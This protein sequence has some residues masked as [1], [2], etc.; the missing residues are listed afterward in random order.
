MRCAAR[1]GWI[2][3]EPEVLVEALDEGLRAL[4]AGQPLAAVQAALAARYPTQAPELRLLLAAAAD[5]GAGQPPASVPPRAQAASRAAFLARAGALRR[6]PPRRRGLGWLFGPA[7]ARPLIIVFVFLAGFVAGT[8]GAVVAS[9]GALPGD[10]LYTVK[11]TVERTQLLLAGDPKVRADLEAEFTARRIEEVRAVATQRRQTR[12]EFTGWLS[13]LEG[14]HWTVSG[15]PVFVPA[16]TPITGTPAPGTW[17]RLAGMVRGDGVILAE[18][19]S[20]LADADVPLPTATPPPTAAV[21]AG[22]DV[23]FTGPVQSIGAAAWQIAGQTVRVSAATEIRDNPR[24][25]QLVEVRAERQADGSLLATRIRLADDDGAGPSPSGTPPAGATPGD[26]DDDDDDNENSSGPSPSSTPGPGDD[27]NDNDGDDDASND[28]DD[29]NDNDADDDNGNAG[30][31]DGNANANGNSAADDDDDDNDDDEDAGSGPSPSNTP[32]A[33][34]TSGGASP[35]AFTQA[36]SPS[37]TPRPEDVDFEGT[38]EAVNGSLWTVGGQAVEVTGATEIR[39]NPQVG[40][41]VRV[42]GLRYADGRIVA[43]R[44]EK[45]D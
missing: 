27:S 37:E 11:R 22:E 18:R 21:P 16:G 44:I 40:N 14:E 34:G 19:V 7:L 2:M 13:A 25:G 9:A 38:L 17:I 4:E 42:R 36:P 3:T 35:P 26:D 31:N 6:P 29:G 28:N 8:Y 32:E 24:V 45:E 5:A 33:G 20:V 12:V 1:C 41:Q 43:T 10:A 30:G 23:E 39:D 15:L